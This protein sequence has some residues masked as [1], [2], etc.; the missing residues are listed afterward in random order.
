MRQ[1]LLRRHERMASVDTSAIRAKSRVGK[2]GWA[3]LLVMSAALVYYGIF[4]FSR[5]PNITLTNIAEPTSLAPDDFQQ[6]D[7][8][9]YTIITLVARQH[10]IGNVAL[11]VLALLVAWKGYRQSS[12][13]AWR[14]AW[15][16]VL[17]FLLVA[18]T[19]IMAGGLAPISLGFLSL[20]V[21]ALV[22]Q[23][24]AR[25]SIAS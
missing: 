3:I 17:N 24:L 1:A 22:G 2:F 7:P 10:A 15:V 20:G 18:V 13:W 5:G 19:F 21:V 12:R 9:A 4:W 23:L 14:A 6:G 8:S 25:G 16:L 11:G